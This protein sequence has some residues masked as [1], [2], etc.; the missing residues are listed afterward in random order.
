[1]YKKFNDTH[2]YSHRLTHRQ[3]RYLLE[4]FPELMKCRRKWDPIEI[5]QAIFYLLRT[6]C[7]W[8]LLP[9][10][11]PHWKSVY[12]KWRHWSAKGLFERILARLVALRRNQKGDAEAPTVCFVDSAS[13][14]SGISFSTKG[15]DGFKK[16]KGIKRHIF[17]D[18][19][20][21]LL[22]GRATTANI[23]DG[24][25]A[26]SLIAELQ[27]KYPSLS[28]ILA[29]KGYRGEDLRKKAEEYGIS[30]EC[31]KSNA[32]N[33]GFVPYK[34]RWVVERT[35]SWYDNY[36]RLALNYEVKLPSAS[37]M[38]IAASVLLMLRFV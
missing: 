19:N 25:A 17:V 8:R 35:I 30:M 22:L 3:R 29:D 20:G 16:T 34:G 28:K 38:L 11:Y 9:G 5:L 24:K 4:E 37:D 36:R 12:N 2:I 26:E 31:V 1:M 18:H 13:R 15:V 6:G 32:G 27:G 10:N 7:Q 33:L 23:N 14:R 21:Y